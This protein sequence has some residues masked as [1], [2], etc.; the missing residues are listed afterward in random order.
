MSF[1]KNIF[2]KKNNAINSYQDFWN[3]FLKNEKQFFKTI[4]D[5][6]NIEEKFFD[7]L[8]PKLAELREGYF[9]LAGMLN[10][11]TAELIIT[12]DG[13]VKQFIFVEELINAAPQIAGW[14]FTAFKPAMDIKNL[15]IEMAGDKFNDKNLFFYSNDHAEYPDEIDVT[16]V[17]SDLTENNRKNITNGTYIFLDNFLG[18]LDFATTI[19]NLEIIGKSEAK[20][21]LVPIEKLKDFLIWREKEFIEKYEG[22]R[23][24]TEND[25]YSAF[26][27]ELRNGN[28]LVG[29][30]NTDLLNW[31]SKASHPWIMDVEIK[32]KGGVNGM[33]DKE[34]F[35]L[36]DGIED[37][38]T[39]QLKD[40]EGYLNIGRETADSMRNIYFACRDFKKPSKVLAQLKSEVAGKLEI[41]YNIYKDKYW[42][43]FNRFKNN[44]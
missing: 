36:L 29:V 33:P 10:D 8:S 34:T 3:W 16:I 42:K 44:G 35:L 19:D 5:V 25:G 18:E 2:N 41:N 30:V 4:G 24:N 37:K 14:K 6:E 23:H 38:I 43:T 32:F 15:A 12:A 22:I 31:D 9:F 21:E 28:P 27:A 7:E 39:A 13:D 11:T 1:I 26:E 20:K 40:F 17:H